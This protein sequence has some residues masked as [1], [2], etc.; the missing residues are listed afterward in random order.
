MKYA[1]DPSLPPSLPFFLAP[2]ACL[3]G[4][5]VSIQRPLEDIA[6]RE[7]SVFVPR[8]VDV[9]CLDQNKVWEFKP[10]NFRL[11]QVSKS[12]WRGF[13]CLYIV[14][15]PHYRPRSASSALHPLVCQLRVQFR[16][17]LNPSLTVFYFFV[18]CLSFFFACSFVRFVLSH[19]RSLSLEVTCSARCT[20]TSLLPTTRSCVHPTCTE[21]W[22]R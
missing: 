22:S 15:Q 4:I 10:C 12:C 2:R 17:S 7:G 8:G 20:R 9:P 18:V 3:I 1:N 21:T 19:T 14:H 13:P 11:G 5:A 6:D 16:S